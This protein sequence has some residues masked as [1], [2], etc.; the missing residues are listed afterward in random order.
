MD[1]RASTIQT[2]PAPANAGT[3]HLAVA[4]L[5][6][7]KRGLQRA[8][9]GAIGANLLASQKACHQGGVPEGDKKTNAR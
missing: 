8:E 7:L 2:E 5:L 9:L 4:E 1:N 6:K 3:K